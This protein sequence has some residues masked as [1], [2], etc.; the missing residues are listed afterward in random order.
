MIHYSCDRCRRPIEARETVRY[1]IKMEIEATID[2]TPDLLD[3]DADG[4]LELDELL[5]RV[6]DE[7]DDECGVIYQRKQFDLCPDC[8]RKFVKNPVG[9][10]KVVPFGFSHN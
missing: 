2:A 1:V 8:Y 10:E 7:V 9:R 6:E 5:S 3:D 4:L